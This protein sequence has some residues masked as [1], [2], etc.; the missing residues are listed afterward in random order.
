MY[1][2]Q[3]DL[4]FRKINRKMVC[5]LGHLVERELT[6]DIRSGSVTDDS[7]RLQFHGS[8]I[9]EFCGARQDLTYQSNPVVGFH[10]FDLDVDIDIA[11]TEQ[12][13]T[14]RNPNSTNT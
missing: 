3:R 8:I 11:C 13:L 2:K 12:Q 9:E 5:I 10:G 4:P 1:A 6:D 14:R 7:V